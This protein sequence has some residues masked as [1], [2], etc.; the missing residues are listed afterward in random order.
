MRPIILVLV[1][2]LL[3]TV[4]VV[5]G[6]EAAPDAAASR[7]PVVEVE[8]IPRSQPLSQD[9]LRTTVTVREGEQLDRGAVRE[10]IHRLYATGR[11]EYIEARREDVEG[12]IKLVFET[13]PSWFVGLVTVEGVDAPPSAVRLANVAR[14]SLGDRYLEE[15]VAFAKE[16]MR[17]LLRGDGLFLA[18][19]ESEVQRDSENQQQDIRFRINTGS[20]ATVGRIFLTGR[21]ERATPP[22]TPELV[23]RITKWGEGSSYTQKWI[24]RGLERLR[25]HFQSN[26]HWQSVTRVSG[27]QFNADANQVDLVVDIEPGPLVRVEV[28]GADFSRRQLRRYL[29]VYEEGVVD[30]DLLAEGASNLRDFLQTRGYFSAQV[31]PQLQRQNEDEVVV[32][33][34]VDPGPRQELVLVEVTG[35][36]FFDLDTIRERMLVRDQT[37][38]VRRGRF[39]ESLVQRDRRAIED[40]YRSNGFRNVRVAPSWEHDYR[41]RKNE[42]AVFFRIEEGGLTLVEGLAIEGAKAISEGDYRYLLASSPGQP[43]SEVSIATDRDLILAQYFDAGYHNAEFRWRA[44]PADEP[45]RVKLD[46]EIIEGE[47]LFVR[48][49]IVSGLNHTRPALVQEQLRIVPG[50]PL[51]SN[52]MFE[53]QR[54][55]YDLGIFSKVDVTLQN[56]DGDEPSKNVLVQVTEG[57]RWTA[58]IGGGAEFA[59]IGGNAA[60]LSRP[61][62]SATFSPRVTLELTQLN[63]RGIGH[64]VS[65]RTRFSSL[66]QRALLTYEAPRWTGSDK[67]HMTISG[68]ADTSRNVRTFTGTR[69]EG[70]LQLRHRLSKPSKALYRFTY[71]R[72]SIDQE[73]LQISP[74]LIPLASQPVRVG[75]LSSTY[76]QDR[77]DDPV[78]STRGLFNSVD[79]SFASGVWGSE[80]DFFRILGQNSTYHRL[81]GSRVV[82]ARTLQMGLMMPAGTFGANLPSASFPGFTAPDPR[83]PLSER[84]FS[85]GANSHRGFPFN[86][87]GPRDPTTG[88]PIGGG[89]QLLHSVELRF[90]LRWE[91][92]GGVLF[93]DAGNVYARPEDISFRHQQREVVEDGELGG[94]NFDYMVH[95][96]GLGVRY[97]TPIGPIRLDVAY[98]INPPRFIGFSGTRDE[99]LQGAGTVTNQRISQFQ[100]HF[101]LGQTF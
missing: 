17:E 10:S 23:R 16:Q 45:D 84:F 43:F 56:P 63:V 26:Q 87:A 72:T 27:R 22:M 53:T 80:P 70:A 65:L 91:D 2:I 18:R 54:R 93:H 55:L 74:P 62:G 35:N 6:A 88:F 28:E 101:S 14:L 11:Y 4:V 42:M 30:E 33:Y 77:R 52:A 12:G 98:S 97:R 48:R 67:W 96:V 94:Y 82:F 44:L 69:L 25:K 37:V 85:G 64:T 38:D 46:Y 39:S 99:L 90:P 86:Q 29:P 41:G 8:F 76:I 32:T 3:L 7:P 13:R 66:Q 61:V 47:S 60:D 50:E 1:R 92:V 31:L 95:A 40:L 9:H 34:Q 36:R 73:T 89:A 24:D 20:R 75:L 83:I 81:G 19:V 79:L 15:N 21:G 68:L 51:S 58:G 71:R 57:R 78:D 49:P 5:A 100:F 59:R